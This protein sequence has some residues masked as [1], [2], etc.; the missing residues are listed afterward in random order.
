MKAFRSIKAYAFVPLCLVL[1]VVSHGQTYGASLTCT[2]THKQYT[3]GSGQNPSDPATWAT[4]YSSSETTVLDDAPE[5]PYELTNPENC[6]QWLRE[7]YED[8][9]NLPEHAF[10]CT[11]GG[12]AADLDHQ[13]QHQNPAYPSN[14]C[15]LAT[16]EQVTIGY[17][18]YCRCTCEGAPGSN[19]IQVISGCHV[20]I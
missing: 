12:C 5:C 10:P 7:Y 1:F 18:H 14:G 4:I 17:D 20:E 11:E 2:K 6:P 15:Y 13:C 19:W 9:E 8:Q 16:I 3:G